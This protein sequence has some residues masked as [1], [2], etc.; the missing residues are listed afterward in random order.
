[1]CIRDRP[2]GTLLNL[3]V[4]A[5]NAGQASTKAALAKVTPALLATKGLSGPATTGASKDGSAA[6]VTVVMSGSQN[7]QANWD[8]VRKVRSQAVPAAFSGLSRTT[9]YVTGDAAYSMDGTQVYTDGM[10][11]I[12]SLIHISEPTRPY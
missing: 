2:Q 5:T 12:V 10:L 7:D 9:V 6:W 8:L 3:T 11:R 1:M 4:V